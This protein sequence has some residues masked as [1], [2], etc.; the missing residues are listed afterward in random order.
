MFK[1]RKRHFPL[2]GAFIILPRPLYPN[3]PTKLVLKALPLFIYDLFVQRHDN[4]RKNYAMMNIWISEDNIGY[5]W[6]VQDAFVLREKCRILGSWVGCPSQAFQSSSAGLPLLLM[7]EEIDCLIS[8][9]LGQITLLK[10]GVGKQNDA[11]GEKEK[12]ND[13]ETISIFNKLRHESYQDQIKL[14]KD[15]R[16]QEVLQ[17]V[18][19]ILEGKKRKQKGT[20]FS[21]R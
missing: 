18:D 2:Q 13:E 3:L 8:Y 20:K 9:N 7:P 21:K 10:A 14:Y 1:Y 15:L 16:K 17:I 11:G 19:K 12:I 4:A 6:N 5:V